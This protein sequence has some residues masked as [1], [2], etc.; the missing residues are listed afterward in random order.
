MEH[1]H[2]AEEIKRRL[3]GGPAH[4]YLRDWIYGGIDGAVTTFAIVSGVVGGKLPYQ[5]VL[6]LGVANLLADGFSMAASNYSGTRAEHEELERVRAMEF[7][8]IEE[9][10]EGEREEVR[11][12]Y[13]AKG[14]KG[15]DLERVVRVITSDSERW[16]Q[17]M[18]TEE[19][20]LPSEV[21]SPFRAAW[22]TFASFAICGVVPLLPF[23]FGIEN[24]F[25]WSIAMTGGTFF[26]IG[27]LRS[28]WTLGR[29]WTAGLET[30]A[31]GSAAAAI[32]YGIGSLLER[33]VTG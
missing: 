28:I 20:G 6:I 32:A 4:S 29:W 13:A 8:H 21:R 14:F 33:I 12:I 2:S 25:A 19:H 26:L 18:L 31:I 15:D 10:P 27:S 17:T 3:A 22:S 1:E 11:Q 30:L 23:I 5:V 24:A 7:R 16:V 9:V